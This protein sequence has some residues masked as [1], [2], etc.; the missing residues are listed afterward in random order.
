MYSMFLQCFRAEQVT[1][2]RSSERWQGALQI[3]FKS[4][5]MR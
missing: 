4:P 3:R 5:L 2:W 1:L